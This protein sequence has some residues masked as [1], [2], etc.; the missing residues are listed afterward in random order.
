[1]RDVAETRCRLSWATELIR[2]VPFSISPSPLATKLLCSTGGKFTAAGDT[3]SEYDARSCRDPTARV[4]ES[5][6]FGDRRGNPG[7]AVSF[8]LINDE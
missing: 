4:I 3:G 2:R 1:M 8:R 5:V 7:G 6:L